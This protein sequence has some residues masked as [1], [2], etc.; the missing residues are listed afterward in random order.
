MPDKSYYWE[1]LCWTT[2]D[3]N[4]MWLF[5]KLLL[6]KKLGYTCGP[7]GTMVPSPDKYI[8][9]PCVNPIGLGLGAEKHNIA[10]RTDH[11][12]PGHFWCE[13]FE[14][15]HM[16]VDY[17]YGK[18]ILT[19]KGIRDDKDLTKWKK[20][21][22]VKDSIDFPQILL[23]YKDKYQYFNCEFIGDKLIEV[24]MRTNPDFRF[25]NSE[26]IPVFKGGSTD[27]P[28]GYRYIEDPEMHGRIGAFIN[29]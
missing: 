1:D 9:R 18:P 26:Y 16:S 17:E 4:D 29:K 5:D 2:V 13:I 14:G 20:W 8:V 27:A 23:P 10:R 3:P 25:G 24:H 21:I 19:V 11:L 7:V 15:D 28:K 12:T 22:K 6:S